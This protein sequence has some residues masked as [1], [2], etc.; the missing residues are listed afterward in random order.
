MV[1]ADLQGFIKSHKAMVDAYAHRIPV[2]F[3]CDF[4]FKESADFGIGLAAAGRND[5]VKDDA[6]SFITGYETDFVD[7]KVCIECGGYLYD[8]ISESPCRA[9]VF[10]NDG[11]GVDGEINVKFGA[12]LAFYPV[13]YVV[14]LKEA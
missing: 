8:V 5:A 7:L 10:C 6:G 9:V 11:V 1:A 3:F 2:V 12:Q 13:N 4:F 14:A